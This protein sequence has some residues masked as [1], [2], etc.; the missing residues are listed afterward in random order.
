METEFKTEDVIEDMNSP[1][2]S[3]ANQSTRETTLYTITD[4]TLV[5]TS[6]T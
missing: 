3:D 5:K 4:T 2:D 6:A 1:L